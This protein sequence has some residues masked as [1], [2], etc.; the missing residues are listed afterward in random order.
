[1]KSS[2]LIILK[3]FKTGLKTLNNKTVTGTETETEKF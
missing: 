1:M 2:R 3:Y